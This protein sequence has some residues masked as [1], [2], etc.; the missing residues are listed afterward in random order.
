MANVSYNDV[1]GVMKGS[2]RTNVAGS[3]FASYRNNKFKFRNELSVNMNK[4]NDSPYGSFAEYSKL[5]P[6]WSP[7]D[8]YG[9]IAKNAGD[10]EAFYG[11]PLYNATLNTKD[12]TAYTEIRDN[13]SMDW[14]ISKA[15]RAV[16][17]FSFTR[18]ESG[19]DVFY[20]AS[21]T[22]FAKYDEN[23]MSDRKGEYTKGDG[24]SQTVSVQ[25]GLNFNKTFG[26]HLL[27]A[28]VTWNMSTARTI[29]TTT[30]A[31]GFGNDYMDDISFATKYQKDGSPS[32]S[33]SR[34]REIGVI[35]AINYSFADRYL[36]DASLRKS[37]SSVYGSDSHWGTFWSLGAGWNVHHEKFLEGNAWIKQ[38]KLRA[39]MG[40]TGTQNVDPS[41]SRARYEYYDYVYG[42]KIGA[43]L[44]ALPN[45]KL[46][47]QRNMDYNLG[48]DVTLK[49]FLT[50]RAD[51]YIQRTDDLLSN[52]SLPPSTGFLTYTENLGKIENR[53]YEL[54]VSVTP[55]R[56]DERQA[57]VTLSATALHNKNKI[58][59]IYDIFKNRKW[60]II[61]KT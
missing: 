58:K 18:Q 45:D 43:Q 53:G 56:D 22:K 47:W 15:F 4:S 29:S 24:S 54:A 30:V 42:D 10:E 57:Y 23:G 49:R 46:K 26:E 55:W 25:A 48:V 44:V 50:L 17:S 52:I 35:G 11:N 37:A 38:F 59:K 39:S 36:F 51:Y 16:G 19:S 32:G 1:V 14:S 31:E 41:Q 21:H 34:S 6:Y 5:N 7:V 61:S 13:F 9:Q 33:N 40:Y 27:F 28:N 60:I 2:D 20:P 8:E 12:E 3:V